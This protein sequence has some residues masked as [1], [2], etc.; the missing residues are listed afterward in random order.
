MT[1]TEIKKEIDRVETALWMCE[2]ADFM[3]WGN[4]YKLKNELR[5]LREALK[6]VEG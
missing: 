1:I 2:M 5:D 6:E 4:Y 3:D